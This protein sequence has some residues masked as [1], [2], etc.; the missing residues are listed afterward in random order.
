MTGEQQDTKQLIWAFVLE[1]QE[2]F[3]DPHPE[4]LAFP[5]PGMLPDYYLKRP[6]EWA[7]DKL[8]VLR[9]K[10]ARHFTD[11]LTGR[12]VS[13]GMAPDTRQ[14]VEDIRRLHNEGH[15]PPEIAERLKVLVAGV[16]NVIAMGQ[17]AYNPKAAVPDQPPAVRAFRENWGRR[18]PRQG[19]NASGT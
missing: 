8:R 12:T 14:L 17:H 2:Y 1:H 18:G 10:S 13:T 19:G 16:N 4:G 9:L 7:L 6:D 11:E 3:C 15:K 5:R